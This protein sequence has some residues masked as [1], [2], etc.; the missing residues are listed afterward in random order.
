M[1]I[2][3]PRSIF[4]DFLISTHL[5]ANSDLWNAV[6]CLLCVFT[7]L[8]VRVVSLFVVLVFGL[9]PADSLSTSKNFLNSL[10]IFRHTCSAKL[11]LI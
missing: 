8:L 11:A 4:A 9:L 2:G 7:L 6:F 3:L 10:P 1:F 5:R